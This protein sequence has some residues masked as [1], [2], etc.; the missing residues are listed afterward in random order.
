M[1]S[2]RA[3]WL[4]LYEGGSFTVDRIG[5]GYI[6]IENWSMSIMGGIQP[7]KLRE[8]MK[9][10][11]SDGLL[12]RFMIIFPDTSQIGN[13]EDD[14]RATSPLIKAGYDALIRTLWDLKPTERT[15]GGCLTV[16]AG[17]G[18]QEERRRLLRLIERINRDPTI[19]EPLKETVNKWQG[20][21]ARLS[22][23]FHLVRFVTK[24]V[25]V[26]ETLDASTVRMAAEWIMRVVAPSTFK[27]YRELG[28]D[29]NPHARW[30]AG[31][32]LAH[33][34]LERL[35][36]R[37][38]GRAYRELRGGSGGHRGDDDHPGA[39]RVGAGRHPAQASEVGHQPQGA[40]DL[41]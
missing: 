15:G 8:M 7:V 28:A 23:I 10:L 31:H 19:P 25:E 18:V 5:R 35:S 39:C 14:D 27:L 30:I 12:Q 4:Q 16:R 11:A 21:L 34:E 3:A 38:I 20:L 33:P 17:P 41:L 24:E 29:G 26:R 1:N 32:I 6:Y 13:I 40:D 37:E 36:P 2:N 22:L 9:N